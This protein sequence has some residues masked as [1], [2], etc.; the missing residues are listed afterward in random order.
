MKTLLRTLVLCLLVS[1]AAAQGGGKSPGINAAMLKMFGDTKA[2]TTQAEARML[3]KN[4]KE[5]S[6]LPMTLAL[7][8]GKMRADMDLSSL[9]GGAI[10]AEA[11]GML[12]QSGMDRMSTLQKP[13]GI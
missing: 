2:F 5:I 7:R 6:A 9:K 13:D 11:A 1:S 12:K 10:P 3:D 4:Q 8:D